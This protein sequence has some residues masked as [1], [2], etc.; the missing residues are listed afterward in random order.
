MSKDSAVR[1]LSFLR[2]HRGRSGQVSHL[3]PAR[4]TVGNEAARQVI[5]GLNSPVRNQTPSVSYA[6]YVGYETR[7]QSRQEAESGEA[8]LGMIEPPTVERW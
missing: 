3:A 2:R 7:V 4:R 6:F 1:D 5:D 8:A